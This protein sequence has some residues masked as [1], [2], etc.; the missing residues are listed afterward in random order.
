MKLKNVGKGEGI[1]RLI[2]GIIF[3][4]PVFFI[5]GGIRWILG[6]AGVAVILTAIFGY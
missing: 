6:L 1:F 2:I 5:S 3:I 4:I